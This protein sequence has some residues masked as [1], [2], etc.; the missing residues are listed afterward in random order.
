MLAVSKKLM[1]RSRAFLMI[2]RLSSSLSTHLCVQRSASPKP[3]HPRQIRETSMPVWPSLV[4][5]M[6]IVLSFRRQGYL[7]FLARGPEQDLV[8][9]H[10]LRLADREGDHPRKG[11]GRNCHLLIH[12]AEVL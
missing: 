5:S 10:V 12:G 2:G 9:I 8:H 1:P 7:E 6:R 11:V 4:Y 3:M